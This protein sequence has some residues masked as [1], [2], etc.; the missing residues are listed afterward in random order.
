MIVV[1]ADTNIYMSGF[2]FGGVPLAV[3][4]L[5]RAGA[6]RLAVSEALLAEISGVLYAKF[7]WPCNCS[8]HPGE[9]LAG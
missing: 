9:R 2:A 3:L 6:F 5:A 1:T 4:D 7:A 8:P